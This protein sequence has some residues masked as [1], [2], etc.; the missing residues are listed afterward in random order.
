MEID[1]ALSAHANSRALYDAKKKAAEKAV[2]TMQGEGG[3]PVTMVLLESN[4]SG[5]E[6]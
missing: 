3:R 6:R 1:L 2:R 5:R 4:R